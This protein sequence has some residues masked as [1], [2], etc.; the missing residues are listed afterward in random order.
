[1][2][3]FF[4]KGV[5]K[6]N[7][8]VFLLIV[9]SFVTLFPLTSSA[10]QAKKGVEY[11]YE[12]GEDYLMHSCTLSFGKLDGEAHELV[13]TNSGRKLSELI[14]ELEDVY[15]AGLSFSTN[16][17]ER[18]H[19]NVGF[20]SALNDGDGYMDDYDWLDNS[21]PNQ[22]SDWSHSPVDLIKGYMFDMNVDVKFWSND[23][24]AISGI[25]GFKYDHWKWDAIGGDYIYSVGGGFRNWTGSFPDSVGISYKQS[26]YVPYGGIG[27]SLNF[28]RFHFNTYFK[29][30]PFAWA[31]D[32]DHHVMR[33]LVFYDTFTGIDYFSYGAE[34]SF[35][36]TNKWF[37]SVAA[38]FQEYKETV[39]DTEIE[40][41]KTGGRGFISKGAGISHEDFYLSAT[42][43]FRF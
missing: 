2:N 36:I 29:Y 17:D 14:W 8:F 37:L 15:L 33:D 27:G 31:D 13:Y 3:S 6:N 42:V 20:W 26:F 4:K 1:M 25:L 5:Q 43:G 9:I 40:D 28:S 18:F 32:V 39:G 21:R 22:W 10:M 34:G 30:T 16:P 23:Y 11:Y 24:A 19:F 35:F 41:L 38:D 12:T 7:V